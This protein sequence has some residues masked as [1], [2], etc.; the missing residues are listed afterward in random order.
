MDEN[1]RQRLHI[2]ASRLEDINAVLLDSDMQAVGMSRWM[3]RLSYHPIGS[4]VN[5]RTS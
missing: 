3:T 1:L 2:P 5:I 4:G